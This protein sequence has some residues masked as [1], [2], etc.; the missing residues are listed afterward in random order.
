MPS[1]TWTQ[2]D[3]VEHMN[4]MSVTVP[5]TSSCATSA[6][7]L[8]PSQYEKAGSKEGLGWQ[9]WHSLKLFGLAASL[10]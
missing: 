7:E 8:Y 2:L 3:V 10:P 9:G 5:Q 4:V 6:V 1:A